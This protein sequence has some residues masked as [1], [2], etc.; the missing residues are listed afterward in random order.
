MQTAMNVWMRGSR[1]SLL[2]A[3]TGQ[4]TQRNTRRIHSTRLGEFLLNSRGSVNRPMGSSVPLHLS[5]MQ[6][7]ASPGVYSA[8]TG[9]SGAKDLITTFYADPDDDV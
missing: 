5:P 1:L 7:F 9:S 4:S 2:A 8:R 3:R 6:V